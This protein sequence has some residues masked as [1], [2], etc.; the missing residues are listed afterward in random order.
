VL[1]ACVIAAATLG[2]VSLFSRHFRFG[3]RFEYVIALQITQPMPRL[4][5]IPFP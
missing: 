3:D 5:R 4:Y 2:P 1:I